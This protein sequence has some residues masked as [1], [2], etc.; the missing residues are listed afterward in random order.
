MAHPNLP[1]VHHGPLGVN[2]APFSGGSPHLS[3][4]LSTVSDVDPVDL[5]PMQGAS[6]KCHC[7]RSRCLKL[8][9][10]CFA[11]NVLCHGCK[12]VDCENT[13]QHTDTRRKAVQY[14]LSR[15]R[16]A[17]EPK[18]KVNSLELGQSEFSHIRGCN[19][20]RSNCRKK[21]CE[22]FQAGIECADSCKCVKCANDGSL[23]HL[24]NFGVHNWVLPSCREATGSVIGTESLMMIL[25]SASPE[26]ENALPAPS[27]SPTGKRRRP[28]KHNRANS[29][30]STTTYDSDL[31]IS[32]QLSGQNASSFEGFNMS[33]ATASLAD[34]TEVNQMPPPCQRRR[35]ESPEELFSPTHMALE[36][37]DDLASPT[38]RSADAMIDALLCDDDEFTPRRQESTGSLLGGSENMSMV[39]DAVKIERVI[40]Q[41]L[42]SPRAGDLL[43]P[44][45]DH[46][47]GSELF[48]WMG[49]SQRDLMGSHRG[50]WGYSTAC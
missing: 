46:L 32:P 5:V 39:D 23:P 41:D 31:P 33:T 16:A 49:D 4:V 47:E 8:Y 15:N 27:P 13:Q 12:C 3:S 37:D 36:E 44:C 11:A 22:C 40:G 43:S 17:F 9:C 6:K 7:K 21:Y 10:E 26:I 38:P 14:K 24:R 28:V 45:R 42:M 20:K 29:L 2:P 35:I 19:C 30:D 50:I 48:D 25:P 18:F 34:P 1:L